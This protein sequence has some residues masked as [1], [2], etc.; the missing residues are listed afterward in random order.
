MRRRPGKAMALA[1]VAGV[2]AVVAAAASHDA[3]AVLPPGNTVQQWDKIAEDTVVGSGAFQNEGLIYMAYTSSA[4]NSAVSPGERRG[5]STDAAV[6]QAAYTILSH[7]FPSQA[8]TLDSLHQEALAAIP[9]S[10]AKIVG[11]RYGANAAAKEIADRAGDGR[12]TPITA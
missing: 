5:Q 7:Y 4:I 2:L 1:A 9:D 6:V 8:A 10:Q 12:Q 11:M 3:R